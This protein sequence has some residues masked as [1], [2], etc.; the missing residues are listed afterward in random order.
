MNHFMYQPQMVA[1]L[2]VSAVP[3]HMRADEGGRLTAVDPATMS[4]VYDSVIEPPDA[5]FGTGLYANSPLAPAASKNDEYEKPRPQG[6]CGPED[7]HVYLR[8]NS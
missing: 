7:D 4:G 1:A 3:P 5:P 6:A 2:T 8:L